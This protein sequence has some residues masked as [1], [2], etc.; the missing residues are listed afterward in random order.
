MISKCTPNVKYTKSYPIVVNWV[1]AISTTRSALSKKQKIESKK[2]FSYTE[3]TW[4]CNVPFLSY[5][6]VEEWCIEL[7]LFALHE[8]IFSAVFVCKEKWSIKQR[9]EPCEIGFRFWVIVVFWVSHLYQTNILKQPFNF[10]WLP[11]ILTNK[12]VA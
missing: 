2:T 7:A 3:W 9:Q 11:E 10:H 1:N 12:P 6:K 4:F 5:D 8:S